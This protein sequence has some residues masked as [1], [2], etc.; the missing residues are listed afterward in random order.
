MTLQASASLPIEQEIARLR[1]VQSAGQHAAALA[2]LQ[3][4]LAD[5]PDN[6]DLLLLA[7]SS[8]RHLGQ[9]EA[10]LATLDR[11]AERHPAF[12][13][14]HQERGLC[15]VARKDAP[16]AIDALLAAVNANPA[17]P[18]SWK[19][20]AG[21][22]RLVGD[23]EQAATATAH[24]EALH[25]LP[26]PIVTAT[27]LYADGDLAPAESLIRAFLLGYGDHPEAMR[28]LAKIGM[29]RN[30][31]DDAELLLEAVVAML[32]EHRAARFE[33]AQCLAWRHKY[34]AARAEIARLRAVDPGHFDYRTLDATVSVGLGNHAAAIALYR[35]MLADDPAPSAAADVYLWLGHALKT[36]GDLPAAIDAYRA[37]AALRPGFGDAYWSLAN[38]KTFRF[39]AATM[40]R[41]RDEEAR[42]TTAPIDR[43]QLCFA[44]GKALEDRGEIAASWQC[45]ERGNALQRA[46]SRYRAEILETNTR[47]QIAV[48]TPAFF[49]ARKGWGAPGRDPI[50]ILGLP[51][52]G[53]T[54][55]EQILAS[56]SQVEGTQELADVQRIV[57]ELQGRDPD[58]DHPLYPACLA[59]LTRA[60]ATALGERYLDETR[61]YRTSDRPF[62]I[63]KMPNNFRHVGLIK[64][65]L[66]N[67]R[68]IDARRDP[69]ACCFSNLKQLF[70][71]G[72]EFSYSS[73][74][75]ARYYRTYLDL[76]AHWDVALPGQVLRVQ[77][78]DVVDDLEHSVRTI[79]D[80]CGLDF[81]PAC[82][83]F[84][85]NRRSVRTPSSEQVRQPIFRDGLDQWKRYAPWLQDL[86][87]ALGD[88]VT[89]YR[90]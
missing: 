21:V 90:S 89:R 15:H 87:A 59:D 55:I 75:I 10:S 8:Q 45:Y 85:E 30:V 49:A 53:S 56:H 4:L 50:L 83:A 44:L 28:L 66:P 64:L 32:P 79:L 13:L 42:A 41:M 58:L 3:G 72:Q 6:R 57:Q 33:Y 86:E 34:V 80:F 14:L 2:Q 19:M 73:D 52:S 88:A 77:H 40:A 69:M 71:Q 20:L 82:L 63:D 60:Q 17:L 1:D 5:F 31:Y 11:L 74:D 7:A 70:A 35:A 48:C 65:I 43:V 51:R 78:E 16:A 62:F 61:I 23:T 76:M 39:D 46:T 36:I 24:V 38:L 25:A 26:P 47:E 67:A 37:A 29:A 68:I 22:F 12:S 27:A 9:I 81:E 84:H 54:L 18:M